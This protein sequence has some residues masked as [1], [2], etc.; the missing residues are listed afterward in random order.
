MGLWCIHDGIVLGDKSGAADPELLQEAQ[1]THVLNVAGSSF[2]NLVPGLEYANI[3]LLDKEEALLPF[4][5]ALEFIG[6]AKRDGGQVLVHC[7][8][9]MSRSPALVT[10]HLMVEKGMTLEESI[11]FIQQARGRLFINGGF[12]R[13]LQELERRLDRDH[14]ENRQATTKPKTS[15]KHGV[16]RGLD[17]RFNKKT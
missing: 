15:S 6:N 9:G 8:G 13:Q 16:S 4:D 11:S 1:I 12:L 17:R 2:D 5:E 10:A 3:R 7:R 14:G